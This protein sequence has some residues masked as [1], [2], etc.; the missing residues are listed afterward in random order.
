MLAPSG[1]LA[2]SHGVSGA[3]IAAPA[4][5]IGLPVYNGAST[6]G[7]ALDA[8]LEQQFTD[9]ELIVSDNDSSDATAAIVARYAARD[10]RIR[11]VRQPRNLGALG[12]FA[13]VLEQARGAFF[14]WAAS[15][16]R[17]SPDFLELT[18]AHLEA[19]PQSISAICPVHFEGRPAQPAWVG[20]DVLTAPR[21][22]DRVRT[23]LARWHS[24]SVFYSLWR[25]SVI[26][27]SIPARGPHLGFDWSILLN[28]TRH[29]RSARLDRGWMERG[30]QGESSDIGIL[31][32]A[33]TRRLHWLLPFHAVG[34]A[35]LDTV[36]DEPLATR[37]QVVAALARLNYQAFKAQLR[38]A[39][40]SKHRLR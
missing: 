20:D 39:L 34:R 8:L 3:D 25:R 4:V 21:T 38:H 27:A 14:M 19:D 10:P 26:A 2:A 22:G 35:A 16:D 30:V 29:G 18:V 33:R 1:R 32:R 6:I 28:A 24:N 12:N 31:A 7:A 9:F 23:F 15:D 13:F 11:Y 36:G 40:A 37:L 17:W 5:S